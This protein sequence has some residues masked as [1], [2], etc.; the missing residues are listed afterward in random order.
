VHQLRPKERLAFQLGLVALESAQ[1]ELGM[2]VLYMTL[3]ESERAETIASG[4]GFDQLRQGCE[5][6]S[7]N[8]KD[9]ALRTDVLDTLKAARSLMESRHTAIHGIWPGRRGRRS[10]RLRRWGQRDIRDW[11]PSDLNELAR[12]LRALDDHLDDLTEQ[13]TVALNG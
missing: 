9:N 5:A 6:L 4:L 13:V 10:L 12:K 7:K 11:Q 2:T 8:L 3:L 1:L